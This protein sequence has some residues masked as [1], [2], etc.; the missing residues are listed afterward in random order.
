MTLTIHP[1][2]SQTMDDGDLPL[3][4]QF[5]LLQA[6]LFQVIVNASAEEVMARMHQLAQMRAAAMVAKAKIK[7]EVAEIDQ[8]AQGKKG[9]IM[10]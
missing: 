8:R 5:H 1:D 7:A 10:P 9:I 6:G 3:A 2:G 4:T